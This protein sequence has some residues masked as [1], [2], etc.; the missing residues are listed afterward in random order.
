MSEPTAVE[1]AE[2]VVS[3]AAAINAS[4]ATNQRKEEARNLLKELSHKAQE[5]RR[6]LAPCP[7]KAVTTSDLRSYI[8]AG[9]IAKDQ[10]VYVCIEENV[11]YSYF[12][13]HKVTHIVQ[14]NP[15]LVLEL[16]EF[17]SGG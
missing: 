7:D 12:T 3:L 11:G 15:A 13:V 5:L 14:E 17:S 2:S 16:G 9:H 6:Q 10:P 4:V 8:D 1:L